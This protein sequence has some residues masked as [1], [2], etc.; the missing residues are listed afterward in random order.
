MAA[1]FGFVVHAAQ[2]DAHE[3][4]S[5]RARDGFTERSLAHARRPEEAQNRALHAGLQLL[6]GQ[7]VEDAL[8][9]FL[10]V[11]VVLVEDRLRLSRCRFP[12]APEDFVHGSEVIHSR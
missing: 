12:R 11:V 4:P 9:H 3:F 1:D 5:Q 6:H 8:L 10:Q 2:G 7:V